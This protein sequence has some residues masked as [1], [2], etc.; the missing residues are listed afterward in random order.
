MRGANSPCRRIIH[1]WAKE[2]L[3]FHWTYENSG[4]LILANIVS[5]QIM[6]DDK[7]KRQI[8]YANPVHIKFDLKISENI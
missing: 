4:D 7:F 8:M 5:D 1:S 3:V 2:S 6:H